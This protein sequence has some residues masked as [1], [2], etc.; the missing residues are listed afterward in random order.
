MIGWTAEKGSRAYIQAL[1]AGRES[2]GRYLSECQYK[3]ESQ[4]VRSERGRRIQ[5]KMWEDLVKRIQV[6][7]PDVALVL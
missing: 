5:A 4:Y 2:H 7:G 1:A 6:A 3:T